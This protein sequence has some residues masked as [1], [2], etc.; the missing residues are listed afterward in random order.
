MCAELH[1]SKLIL[2]IHSICKF[3]LGVIPSLTYLFR[4]RATTKMVETKDITI[5]F[6]RVLPFWLDALSEYL[7]Y[8]N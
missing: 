4:E 7:R 2:K 5:L 8:L 1:V 3:N 6:P